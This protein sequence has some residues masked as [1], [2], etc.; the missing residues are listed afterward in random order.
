MQDL[1]EIFSIGKHVTISIYLLEFV[2]E[3][4]LGTKIVGKRLILNVGAC[5]IVNHYTFNLCN[6]S[7]IFAI[8]FLASLFKQ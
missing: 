7:V 3:L 6:L 5:V 4:K 1:C 8:W 2:P